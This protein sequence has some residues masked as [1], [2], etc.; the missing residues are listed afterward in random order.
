MIDSATVT[1]QHLEV[2]PVEAPTA[3]V[4]HHGVESDDSLER[5]ATSITFSKGESRYDANPQRVVA[6]G[7]DTFIDK[8][9]GWRQPQK[10]M[11]YICA[12]FRDGHRSKESAEPVRFICLDFDR[13]DAAELADLCMGLASFAGA[14]WETHSSTPDAP[15]MRFIVIL[16]REATREEILRIG[17]AL[18]A[19]VRDRFGD[20]VRL[21]GSTFKI[22]QPNY[23]PPVGVKLQRYF[24]K[25]LEVDRYL[26]D[27]NAVAPASSAKS[28][29]SIAD[30]TAM[31]D[32]VL[33]ALSDRGMVKSKHQSPGWFNV[34]CPCS[35]DHTSDSQETTTTY[36]L[37]NFGGV[38]YGKFH[39]LHDHCRDRPQEQFLEALGLNPKDVWREQAGPAA[40]DQ[41]LSTRA[42]GSGTNIEQEHENGEALPAPPFTVVSFADLAH[43]RPPP[44]AFWWDGYLPA[45]VVTLLGAHGGTGK[46]TIALML[47]VCVALG[48]PLFGIKTRRGRVAFYNGEDAASVV[49]HRLYLICQQLGVS[50]KDL[51]GWMHILDATDDDPTLFHE[52]IVDGTRAGA[53][54]PTYDSLREYVDANQID[55]LIVDNASDTYDASEIDRARVRGFMRSLARIAKTRGG[56]VLLLAHVDKGVARNE[57]PSSEGYSGSTAWHNS[58]RSRLFLSREDGGDLVLDHQKLNLLGRPREKLRLK[59]PQDG[60]PQAKEPTDVFAAINYDR[61]DTLVLLKLIHEFYSRGEFISTSP[62]SP[63]NAAKALEG[64]SM[65]P[66]RRSKAEVFNL[67]RAAERDKYIER[68]T[69][70][71]T[72]RKEK[73]RWALTAAGCEWIGVPAPSAPSAPSTDDGA[74]GAA[75]AEAAGTPAPPSAGGM[76]E[77]ARTQVDAQVGAVHD[78]EDAP[79][80]KRPRRGRQVSARPSRD[81]PGPA[82]IV[83]AKDQAPISGAAAPLVFPEIPQDWGA[84]DGSGGDGSPAP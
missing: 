49:L 18:S 57:R 79:Q 44:P 37:P 33:R 30:E 1:A 48:W 70:R 77:S 16:D 28:S 81:A 19:A 21:D 38:K 67:L 46:S 61:P 35:S 9:D 47:A 72:D 83:A 12:A 78:P 53:T 50:V 4:V 42:T 20:K 22:E 74:H 39:C 26:A 65:Y 5:T 45:G 24:G 10:H 14:G 54:T 59:W 40:A 69:Y 34:K 55:V 52:V 32:P 63:S 66:H 7:I 3:V 62:Q 17:A 82:D 36:M 60:V 80:P 27:L 41:S 71:S 2:P 76:G 15:R 56:A 68:Q 8:L 58:A 64:E 43:T 51:E 84:P 75:V 11:G 25:P 13:V 6:D 31:R 23:L 73:E 29:G